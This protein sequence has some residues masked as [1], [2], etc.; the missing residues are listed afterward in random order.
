[1]ATELAGVVIGRRIDHG[2]ARPCEFRREP[3]F[4]GHE[5]KDCFAVLGPAIDCNRR[6]L[7]GNSAATH[8]S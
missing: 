4:T 5:P 8:H 2:P 1:M 3:A 7:R 6:F